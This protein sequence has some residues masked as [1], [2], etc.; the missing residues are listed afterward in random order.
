MDEGLCNYVAKKEDPEKWHGEDPSEWGLDTSKEYGGYGEKKWRCPHSSLDGR[1]YCIFHTEPENY[2]KGIDESK[3]LTEALSAAGESPFEDGPEHRGQFVGA[4]FGAL[5]LA[6]ETVVIN[7]HTVRFDHAKFRGDGGDITFTGTEFVVREDLTFYRTKFTNNSNGGVLFDKAEFTLEDEGTVWFNETEF[8][9]KGDGNVLFEEVRFISR[10]KGGASFRG[11]EF[12]TEDNGDIAFDEAEFIVEGEGNVSFFQTKFNTKD[13]GAISFDEAEFIVEGGGKI[14]FGH[15]SPTIKDGLRTVSG[16]EFATEGNGN[17]SFKNSKF[18]SKSAG[19]VLFS[20]AD[21]TT[22]GE[23]IVSFRNAEFTAISDGSVSFDGANL[24]ANNKKVTFDDVEFTTNQGDISF[25]AA[26]F[27]AAKIDFQGIS[28]I[29]LKKGKKTRRDLSNQGVDYTSSQKSGKVLFK[30]AEFVG[31]LNFK[32]ISVDTHTKLSF[33]SASIRNNFVFEVSADK[34]V[35]P[36][37]LNFSG[38]EFFEPPIFRSK[39]STFDS[40]RITV[41]E[42]YYSAVFV[43]PVD[44]SAVQLPEGT[45]FS[46][47][48]FA[49]GTTFA[50]ADLSGVNF[51]KAD[52]SGT[53]LELATLN[54]AELLGTNLIGAKFYGTLLGDARINSRT[55]FWPAYNTSTDTDYTISLSDLVYPY[56]SPIPSNAPVIRRIP[57]FGSFYAH[58]KAWVRQ[59]RM[60]YC[61]YDPRYDTINDD[62][63]PYRNGTMSDDESDDEERVQLEKAAEVY[64]TVEALAR[65]NGLQELASEA[66]VGR[67]DVQRRQYWRKDEHG[68]QWLMWIRSMVPNGI[69][70][71]GESPWRVLVTGL[72]IVLASGLV[73][74]EF[75][76]IEQV[77]TGDPA[78]L[79]ESIYFSSL[80]F[81]TLGY[82]DFRP[83]NIFGQALAVG[84][85]ATGVI[86]LAIL[87]FVFGRRATR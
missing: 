54:R 67:K 20:G 44:F 86:M 38:V 18:A 60:P 29:S 2:P 15:K 73:Y 28:F 17:V 49:E 76:L 53:T 80:T 39:S 10:Q 33:S 55:R 13:D 27:D 8:M 26:T 35:I 32:D 66:F 24:T 5:N 34:P 40:D 37:D 58:W 23:G 71:Y 79:T 70:R 47:A 6:E 12:T 65:A 11:A 16:V 9:A 52:L 78:T 75:E 22:K 42:T 19:D 77:D 68:R 21:F 3:A 62:T 48:K 43:S 72:F 83:A 4:T 74:W 63:L 30:D 46:N 25:Q 82:G 64:G 45:D 81:T 7:K 51:S 1:D 84:E 61:W 50:S 85:T 31:D 57:I 41:T 36:G 56:N 69:A 87:V 59:G 14:S